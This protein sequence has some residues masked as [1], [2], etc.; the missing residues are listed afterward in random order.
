MSNI[1]LFVNLEYQDINA[2]IKYDFNKILFI[3]LNFV[4]LNIIILQKIK[5]IEL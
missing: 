4:I 2:S 1:L 3:F 5:Y